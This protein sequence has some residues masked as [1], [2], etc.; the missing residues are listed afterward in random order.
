MRFKT[1]ISATTKKVLNYISKTAT[2]TEPSKQRRALNT[3]N[4]RAFMN[5]RTQS[6]LL[7]LRAVLS[8]ASNAALVSISWSSCR[9]TRAMSSWTVSACW[10]SAADSTRSCVA[11]S[12]SWSLRVRH[13]VCTRCASSSMDST[14]D[15][16]DSHW[17]RDMA[18]GERGRA[19][20]GLLI[21]YGDS[22]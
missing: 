20:A 19:G 9:R 21:F 16:T 17:S 8:L 2:K 6:C 15:A 14:L 1:I 13:W 3:T 18:C 4:S 12:A 7:S 10:R 5:G 22:Q 11:D